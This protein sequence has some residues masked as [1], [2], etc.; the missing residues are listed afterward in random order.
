MC[1]RILRYTLNTK[2]NHRTFTG[3]TMIDCMDPTCGNSRAHPANCP[4]CTH[5]RWYNKPERIVTQE[6]DQ[7][8]ENCTP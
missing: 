3:D 4:N 5:N 1:H 7:K 8:C 2:C 6:L